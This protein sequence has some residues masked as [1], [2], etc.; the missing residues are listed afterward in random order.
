MGVAWG[1]AQDDVQPNLEP[2]PLCLP[3]EDEWDPLP[4]PVPP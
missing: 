1:G 4:H 3:D 2:L